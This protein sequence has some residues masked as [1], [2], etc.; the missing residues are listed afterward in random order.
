MW[1]IPL[2]ARRGLLVVV[3]AADVCDGGIPREAA[4]HGLLELSVNENH[5]VSRTTGQGKFWGI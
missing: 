1:A 2:G 3:G 4:Q 5:L